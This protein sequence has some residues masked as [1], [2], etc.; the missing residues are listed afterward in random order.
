MIFLL[1]LSLPLP[2]S[3]DFID[4]RRYAKKWNRINLIARRSVSFMKFSNCDGSK[5]SFRRI[6]DDVCAFSTQ[7]SA[8]ARRYEDSDDK[9]MV[10][11][12]NV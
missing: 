10:V 5:S 2:T 9:T 3:C 6:F 8:L 12:I 11:N 4:S 7:M 1:S